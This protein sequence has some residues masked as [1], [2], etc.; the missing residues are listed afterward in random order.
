[1]TVKSD[2]CIF[3]KSIPGVGFYLEHRLYPAEKREQLCR[4]DKRNR[5]TQWYWQTLFANNAEK[6]LKK[7]RRSGFAPT[8][9]SV[10]VYRVLQIIKHES[11]QR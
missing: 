9:A 11:A 2:D 4:L 3:V 1:M 8:V 7:Y 6:F 10:S 5:R